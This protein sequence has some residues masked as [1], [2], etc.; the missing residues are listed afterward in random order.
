MRR[1]EARDRDR[2]HDHGTG[3]D[4]ARSTAH[5]AG[6]AAAPSVLPLEACTGLTLA[7]DVAARIP[8]PHYPSSAMDGWAV[9]GEGPWQLAGGPSGLLHPG[10]AVPVV[11]G[12]LMPGGASAV[13]RSEYGS[14]RGGT[15]E[16]APGVAAGEPPAG[17]HIRPAGEETRAGETVI[18][19]GTV[20]NPAHL[21]IAAVCGHDG[22]PVTRRPEVALLLTG[23]EVVTAG[24]PPPGKVRD[25]FGPSLPAIVSRLGG[26]PAP[27][28]RLPDEFATL[29]EAVRG[30]G[31]DVVVTTGGTGHSRADHVRAVLAELGARILVPSI[32]MRPGHPALLA[33]LPDG[34]LLVGLPGNPLAAIMALLTL[35]APLLA[36]FNALP[37]PALGSVSAGARL[38]PLQGRDRL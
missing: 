17:R 22:L 9:A 28:V 24:I 35:G 37:L 27:P 34:R 7:A 25:T 12:G 11:T 29:L 31:A 1:N 36:G 4:Q 2:G 13:L 14:V 23:H 15:L 32:R 30:C 38:A 33:A 3:W 18:T 6:T 10:Q 8:V 20:L 5:A 16:L 19:A 21:A 26:V